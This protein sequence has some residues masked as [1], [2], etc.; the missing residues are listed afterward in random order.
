MSYISTQLSKKF[1]E[2]MIWERTKKGRVLNRYPA[3][4]YFYVQDEDGAFS[5]IYGNK[6]IR[7][8]FSTYSEFR[9]KRDQCR[10][11]GITTYESD[12]PAD[13]KILSEYYHNVDNT[14]VHHISFYD[15]EVDYDRAQGMADGDNPYA[16]ISAIS[17][18][19]YWSRKTYM[20]LI[21]PHLSKWEPG[22]KWT[23]NDLSEETRSLADIR[24]YNSEKEL[25]LD[26]FSLIEDTDYLSGWNSDG[27]D[28]PYLYERCIR[29]FGNSGKFMLGGFPEVREPVYKEITGK[30]GAID[31]T[32]EVF[33]RVQVDYMRL[34]QKFEA[35]MRSSYS[36][37]SIT[38]EFLPELSK[39]EYDGSLYTLYRDDFEHFVRYG[40]R[41]SECL[42]GFEDRLGYVQR[43]ILLSHGATAQFKF[44]MGTLK[45]VENNIINF[46]HHEANVK[47]PDQDYS[48][49]DSSGEK[50][51]GAAVLT[52]VPGMYERLA[53]IDIN[54]L[55]PSVIR[56]LNASP[57]TIVGHFTENHLDYF[58]VKSES[59]DIVLFMY[60][61]GTTEQKTAKE[62]K[63]WIWDNNYSISA[64]GSVFDNN[65]E[66]IFPTILGRWY[67][68]RKEYQAKKRE[69]EAK[70][71]KIR[72]KYR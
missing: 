30:F 56:S 22:P 41:D 25:L 51:T 18:F 23:L 72:E 28:V 9:S 69:Y 4:W 21:S 33:G 65:K 44:V 16:P 12:I 49:L 70:M 38:E 43:A 2:V 63:E 32:L 39:L 48:N 11:S 54:S 60:D 15:I 20:L 61:N 59:D 5:D 3:P 27:Y 24:F 62:W 68:T 29:L 14:T 31:K 36:L 37:E 19:H 58:K 46:C 71:E 47:V 7:L 67:T 42:E 53:A 6:L 52:P 40:I 50:F 64:Y 8:D 35:E 45:I 10:L 26:F 66:G 57:E 34:F 55:Y 13:S 1:D 17:L